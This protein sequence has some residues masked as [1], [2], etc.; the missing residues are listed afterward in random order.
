MAS[1]KAVGSLIG[2]GFLL[3]IIAVGASYW[4]LQQ[5]VARQS[6]AIIQDMSYFDKNAADEDIDIE[7]IGLTAGN[8]FNLTVKN[9]GTVF[10]QLEWLSV[11]D[12]DD[13]KIKYYRVDTALNPLDTRKNVG[14]TTIV[15][16][17]THTYTVNILT[18]LGN[19][20]NTE[21]PIPTDGGGGDTG[22]TTETQYYYVDSSSDT[23]SPTDSGSYSLFNAMK[24]GPDHVNNTLTEEEIVIPSSTIT[25][26]DAES[27]EGA[28]AT[29]RL[30]I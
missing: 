12:V 5:G 4:Q 20:Y 6:D 3:M 14:N 23:Y 15:V 28:L 11:Y 26:I 17:P 30:D 13:N 29:H 24:A 2:I 25:L 21:Y 22:G 8:S 16:N 19:S 9:T 27:F 10:S 7:Y 1:R 18:R